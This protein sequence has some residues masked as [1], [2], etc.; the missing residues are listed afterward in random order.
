MACRLAW[1]NCCHQRDPFLKVLSAGILAAISGF[2]VFGLTNE[3][4]RDSESIM[5]LWFLIGITVTIDRTQ[6]TQ[7]A[8]V[9]SLE[10]V[11]D[12]GNRL[13]AAA[14][15]RCRAASQPASGGD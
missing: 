1:R 8:G 12:S 3:N 15:T 13:P 2:L 5:Q 4:S 14:S 11:S 10:A 7:E 6:P 9:M